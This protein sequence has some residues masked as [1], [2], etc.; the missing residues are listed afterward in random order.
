MFLVECFERNLVL[1]ALPRTQKDSGIGRSRRAEF[2][3]NE[4]SDKGDVARFVLKNTI[5]HCRQFEFVHGPRHIVQRFKSEIV[6]AK[7]LLLLFQVE[8]HHPHR[9]CGHAFEQRGE[10]IDEKHVVVRAQ[11]HLDLPARK[12][13]PRPQNGKPHGAPLIGMPVAAGHPSQGQFRDGIGRHGDFR[14]ALRSAEFYLDLPALA[15]HPSEIVEENPFH[16]IASL[17][18]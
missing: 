10:N 16:A 2:L 14:A 18:Q 8:Y 6:A 4:V 7:Q 9:R 13:R 3:I 11:H 5:I 1:K 12:Q 17:A 15:A